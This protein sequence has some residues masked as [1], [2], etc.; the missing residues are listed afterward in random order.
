MKYWFWT[1]LVLPTVLL[2]SEMCGVGFAGSPTKGLDKVNHVIIAMQENHSFDNYFGVLV[3]AA[4]SPYHTP[5]KGSCVND[6][7]PTT[8][9]EGLSCVTH[10]DGTYFCTNSNPDDN[11]SPVTAFHLNDYCP[12][13]D[14]DHGW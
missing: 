3:R 1:A 2:G 10:R 9:V 13:P 8:C 11:G 12:G 4:G 6:S 7:H 14:L 5:V